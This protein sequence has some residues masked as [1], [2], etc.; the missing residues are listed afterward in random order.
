[1]LSVVM[2]Y[3][4]LFHYVPMYGVLLAFKDFSVFKGITASPWAG[5]KYFNEVFTDANFWRVVT[6]TVLISTY[7]ILFSFPVPI[8]LAILLNELTS[9][10]FKK[11]VQTIIYLP[12]F[13]SWVVVAGLV[14]SFLSVYNGVFNQIIVYFGW[15]R[16][17]FLAEP[18][19]F[20]S[21]LVS[22]DIWKNAGWGT[23]IYIAAI[24][25]ISHELY[26]AAI[27]DGANRFKQTLHITLPG[28]M[29]TIVVLFILNLAQFLNAG[30]DQVFVMYNTAV[31]ETG[32]IIDTYAYRKGLLQ[33]EYSYAT[34][35]GLFKSVIGLT[36][37]LAADKFFK[38]VSGY[39]IF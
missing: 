24:T 25:G 38:K 20:R 19:F 23:I 17:N 30:F 22:S 29:P 9:I 16:I 36:L 34:V 6:N 5:F 32:D 7:K 2:T 12:H 3:Y 13:V 31:M 28:I 4:V 35:V 39:G 15:E 14:F 11:A 8:I 21:I 27:V 1:M 10:R 18:S 33:G 37:I 26:E